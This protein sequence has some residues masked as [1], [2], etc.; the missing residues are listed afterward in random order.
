M[1][2]VKG[3]V[4]RG[5]ITGFSMQQLPTLNNPNSLCRALSVHAHKPK[6]HFTLKAALLAGKIDCKSE[7]RTGLSLCLGPPRVSL[8]RGSKVLPKRQT[9][10]DK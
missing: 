8:Q 2:G 10:T 3:A 1:G 7:V 4:L 5:D 9:Q 6:L